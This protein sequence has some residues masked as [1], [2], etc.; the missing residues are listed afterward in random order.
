M[1]G[2]SVVAQLICIKRT[3]P[4]ALPMVLEQRKRTLYYRAPPPPPTPAMVLG[5]EEN[6]IFFYFRDQANNGTS[7]SCEGIITDLP[8]SNLIIS[9][10]IKCCFGPTFGANA[11]ISTRYVH[12]LVLSSYMFRYMIYMYVQMYPCFP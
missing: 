6:D 7:I 4:R 2:I 11:T 9:I 3:L 8:N 10:G 1:L 5:T 12:Q